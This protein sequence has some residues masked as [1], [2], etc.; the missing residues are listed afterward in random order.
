MP[1]RFAKIKKINTTKIDKIARIAKSFFKNAVAGHD[2]FHVERVYNLAIKIGKIEKADFDLLKTAA[3]LH[4]IARKYEDLGK[5]KCHGEG[6]AKIAKKI[7]SDLR[8]SKEEIEKICY[9][10]KAHRYKTQTKPI[11]LEAKILQDADRLDALGAICISRVFSYGGEHLRPIYDP[12]IPPNPH[13]TSNAATSI[14]HFFEKILKL[15]PETFNTKTGR[16]IAK[17]RYKYT[18]EFVERFLK[19]W[20]GKL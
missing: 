9:A 16:K 15:K 17:D 2:W 3:L 12:K 11:T 7:L 5:V 19:E 6:G 4:D 10:I 13:Y 18:Q 14:N 1:P 20:K 8:F